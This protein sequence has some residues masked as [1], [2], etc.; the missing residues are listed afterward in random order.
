MKPDKII[1]LII[2]SVVVLSPL[3]LYGEKLKI[4]SDNADAALPQEKY[5]L[6]N[7]R[8]YIEEKFFHELPIEGGILGIYSTDASLYFI[9]ET[10][11]GWLAGSFTNPEENISGY[12][13]G[14]EFQ[15]LH[16]LICRDNIFYLLADI[17]NESNPVNTDGSIE[18]SAET[19]KVIVRFD[20]DKNEKKIIRGVDDF[21]L[22]GE[23]LILLSS[24]GLQ[25][26]G[27][28]IPFT[29][30]GERFIDKIIDGRFIFLSNG[31]EFEVIDIV[32]QRNIYAYRAGKA[33]PFNPDYNI[34]LEFNDNVEL[35]D[36]VSNN[37]NMIYYRINV[38]GV[39]TGRT[40]TAL[41]ETG[42][43]SM[44]KA[45]T[46]RYCLIKA[47]RWELDKIKGR[48]VRVNNIYQPETVKLYVPE[49]RIVKI[50]FIFDGE[51][52]IMNQSVYEN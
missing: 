40:E 48:Y 9:K 41:S 34:I 44:I 13:L 16:K 51:K 23:E 19:E 10:E 20:P 45:E 4:F 36:A 31:D 29:L 25:G 7:G 42:S 12:K 52:Y 38:N 3:M 33:F 5:S 24:S 49:N 43:S 30:K 15:V 27:Y 26:N 18:L 32:S 14:R 17:I 1:P 11:D 2:L 28:L 8:I 46:G 21:V 47:E 22:I 35:K 39:E 50:S 6:K 37:E